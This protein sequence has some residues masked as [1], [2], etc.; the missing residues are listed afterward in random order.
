MVQSKVG[1]NE[2]QMLDPLFE[3]TCLN[4]ESK[5]QKILGEDATEEE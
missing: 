2:G 1:T 5:M 3:N 4:L